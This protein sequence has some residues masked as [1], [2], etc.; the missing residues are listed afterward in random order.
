MD[1][2]SSLQPQHYV[3]LL[4]AVNVSPGLIMFFKMYKIITVNQ[5]YLRKTE[6][7]VWP[8]LP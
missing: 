2:S 7:L 3:H 8:G 4:E 5:K 6:L 1:L